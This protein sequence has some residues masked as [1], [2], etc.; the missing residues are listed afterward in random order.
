MIALVCT[1]TPFL[2]RPVPGHDPNRASYLEVHGSFWSGV[3]IRSRRCCLG[4]S[5]EF[6]VV[7][8]ELLPLGVPLAAVN[9]LAVPALHHEKR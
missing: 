1:N 3:L 9:H 8:E 6:L 2:L 7:P 5:F 4:D